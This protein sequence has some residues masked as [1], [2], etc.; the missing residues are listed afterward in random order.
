MLKTKNELLKMNKKELNTYKWS[1]EI[2]ESFNKNSL[3][4]N[5]SHCIDCSYCS[6]CSYCTDCSGCSH[7]TDCPHCS[8]CSDCS[9]CT[10]CFGCSGCTDCFDCFDCSDCFNCRNVK[11]LKYAICN[12]EVGKEAYFNKMKELKD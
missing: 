11:G 3:C 5:C 9:H 1:E 7:C 4:I 6:G 12:M 2:K 10:D 8:H